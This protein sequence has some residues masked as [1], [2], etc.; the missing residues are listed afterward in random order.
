MSPS[1]NLILYDFKIIIE[2]LLIVKQNRCFLKF[3]V[4]NSF[5]IQ[6]LF[7]IILVRSRQA[8]AQYQKTVFCVMG[9]MLA[10]GKTRCKA[11][12]FYVANPILSAF[13]TIGLLIP[14]DCLKY[15]E[16]KQQNVHI[17]LFKIKH[18]VNLF[19]SLKKN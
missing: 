16:H 10:G 6:I 14:T 15:P 11:K 12:Y 5:Q 17:K 8:G 13:L 7:R 2:R 18:K 3:Q 1:Y 4:I 9:F 19:Y